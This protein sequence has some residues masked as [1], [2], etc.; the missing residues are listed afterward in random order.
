MQKDSTTITGKIPAGLW[1]VVTGTRKALQSTVVLAKIIIP[2][3]F[4]LVALDTLGWLEQVA[5][6]F[7][8]MLK[9]FG[10]PG[11]AALPIFLGFFINIYAAIG[12]IAVLAL[13]AREIT[14]IAV[15]ILT[16]HSLLMESP[17]LKFTGLSPLTSIV[18]R[19]TGA[20]AIGFL[21]NLAYLVLGG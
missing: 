6:L 4:V 20:F 16:C 19:I 17:V 8:P 21:L 3:T 9:I 10:L 18:L 13:S 14:V 12:A 7:A 1:P 11:K 2:V 15:M 5:G